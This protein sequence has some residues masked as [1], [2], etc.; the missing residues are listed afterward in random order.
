M[1]HSRCV[2]NG[3]FLLAIPLLLTSCG[4]FKSRSPQPQKPPGTS[5]FPFGLFKKKVTPPQAS[6]P[7]WMGTITLVNS[8]SHYVLIDSNALYAATPG[9]ILTCLSKNR[10]TAKVR[11]SS[12]K[13]PPF[14]IADIVSGDPQVGERVYAPDIN[15]RP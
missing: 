11:V 15:H 5:H 12:D 3:L 2:K 7:L 4:L 9:R 10:E 8:E 14:F 1:F 6:L 13:N